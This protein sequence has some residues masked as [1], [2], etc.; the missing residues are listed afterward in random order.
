VIPFK[1]QSCQL[2][3]PGNKDV[4]ADFLAGVP[5]LSPNSSFAYMASGL[6]PEEAEVSGLPEMAPPAP[7]NPNTV[8]HENPA[9]DAFGPRG[10]VTKRFAPLADL[11]KPPG[12]DPSAA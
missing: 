12:D 8:I 2:V 9:Q 10:V 7:A 6:A 11:A 4:Y 5:D 1:H 3:R